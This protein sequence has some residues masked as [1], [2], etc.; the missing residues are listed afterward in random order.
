MP[1]PKGWVSWGSKSK[2]V[3]C[4]QGAAG[5]AWQPQKMQVQPTAMVSITIWYF[6]WHFFLPEGLW[7]S[8]GGPG[9]SRR[10]TGRRL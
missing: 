7:G 1:P 6:L 4:P 8:S 2:L 3:R 10:R 9:Q 5:V